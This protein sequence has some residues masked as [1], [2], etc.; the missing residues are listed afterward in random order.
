VGF[1]SACRDDADDFSALLM[2][3]NRVCHDHYGEIS[4][5]AGCPPA[6]L[7]IDVLILFQYLEWIREDADST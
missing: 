1:G 7:S 2:I 5:C 3:P 4:N 6:L